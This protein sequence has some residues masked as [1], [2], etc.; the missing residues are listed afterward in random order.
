VIVALM[1]FR[2]VRR[3]T[4]RTSRRLRDARMFARALKS[5]RHPILAQIV[6]IRRC[7]LSC[8]YCNEYDKSSDPVPTHLMLRR[9]DRLAMLGTSAI[10]ISGG[11]P[12]LHPD[13][14]VIIRQIRQRG[15]IAG[16]LTNGYLLT[17]ERIERL[18]QAGLDRLQ[19]S[20]DNVAPNDVSH[21]SLQ[22]IDRR[23][24]LLSAHAEFDVNIN[25]V[26][27][28]PVGDAEDALAIARR[29]LAL[30]FNASTGLIHDGHGQVAALTD[31]HREVY[32]KI[33][34]LTRG[35]FSHAHDHV[36]QWNLARG[37]PNQWHCRAGAR[38]LYICEDGLVH[39]C[40]QQRG[41]PGRPLDEY[42]HEDLDR[43][44]GT[45]KSCAPYCTVSCV[46]RIALLDQMR[47]Q[48][49][50]TIGT[51]LEAHGKQGGRTPVVV[52]LLVWTFLNGPFQR[53]MRRLASWTLRADDED[54]G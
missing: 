20:I 5:P 6:P 12:L 33:V 37:L 24:E 15:I 44:L 19:I 38:Y 22:V 31:R 49:Q 46:H 16:L 34:G 29:G 17:R 36:F 25:T 54:R 52:K 42:S 4:R 10:D 39:W 40:S 1:S 7:N 32:D 51:V 28:A 47:E 30:G 27:G 35:F 9:V 8:A 11:E 43:E 3:A 23:L 13:L 26:L 41:Y 53:V 48:P 2:T 45:P 18:N 50:E 21:K 14:D